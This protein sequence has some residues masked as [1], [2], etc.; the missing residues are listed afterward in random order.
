MKIFLDTANLDELKKSAAL[1]DHPLTDKGLAQFLK[2]H[3]KVF[4]GQS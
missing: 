1:F 4:A 2:D 3:A